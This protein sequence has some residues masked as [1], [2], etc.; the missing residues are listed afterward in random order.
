MKSFRL[1]RDSVREFFDSWPAL[2]IAAILGGLSVY[3]GVTQV[4]GRVAALLV[5]GV[6]GGYLLR[7]RVGERLQEKY[8]S[9]RWV[10]LVAVGMTTAGFGVATRMAFPQ[11][12]GS[13]FDLTWLAISFLSILVFVI[14]NRKN[15]DVVQ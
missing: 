12:Q 13:A 15:K 9:A 6:Y 4:W 5:F 11:V 14:V 3:F 10:W 1:D 7:G 2:V 8:P